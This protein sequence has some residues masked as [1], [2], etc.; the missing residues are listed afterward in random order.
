MTHSPNHPI[1]FMPTK[2]QYD[3][4]V[5]RAAHMEQELAA[6]RS[7]FA[8]LPGPDG[9]SVVEVCLRVADLHRR[10]AETIAARPAEPSPLAC[11]WELSDEEGDKDS[12]CTGCGEAFTLDGTPKKKGFEFCPYCGRTLEQVEP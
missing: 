6:I 3:S 10:Q 11:V 1:S 7:V 9:E 5:K 12:W 2:E 8:H 4:L